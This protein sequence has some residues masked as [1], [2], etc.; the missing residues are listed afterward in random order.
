MLGVIMFFI[1]LTALLSTLL[2][3]YA[4]MRFRAWRKRQ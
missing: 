3:S 1:I 2:V 4:I